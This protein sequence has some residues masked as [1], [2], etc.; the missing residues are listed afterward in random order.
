MLEI[1][2]MSKSYDGK[3]Q[4][5]NDIN[6]QIEEGDIYGFIGHNGAGKTTLLKSI[7]G[8]LDF[9]QGDILINGISIKDRPLEAKK[10]MAYIPD[11]PD[12]YE[13]LTG[14][15]YLDFIADVYNVDLNER[16]LRISKYATQF[17]IFD[18][19][20]NPIA[21]YSHGM[22]QKLVLIGALIHE[23]KILLL[24]EPFVGLDP[25]ASY[26]VKEIFRDMCAR[27]ALIF[28]STHV[29]EVVEKLC[30]KVAIIK[31]GII[32]ANG[33]TGEI[34]KDQSLEHIFLE[35]IKEA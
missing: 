12:V 20:S 32:V 1:I 35:L 18:V 14:I 28:F 34:I 9:D 23:P 17:E 15:Q 7:I 26:Q 13:S 27:G 4:A 30:N 29:L 24:D 8:I 22:K 10:I 5:C 31:N 19:L 2:H 6:L 11:N 16:K 21:S 33:P 25:K 3:K